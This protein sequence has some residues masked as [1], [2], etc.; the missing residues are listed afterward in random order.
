[1]VG[2]DGGGAGIELGLRLQAPAQY[3]EH[4]LPHEHTLGQQAAL[5]STLGCWVC[6]QGTLLAAASRN[7]AVVQPFPPPRLGLLLNLLPLP[8]AADCCP[9]LP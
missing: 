6:V 7:Q 5:K 2:A 8:P 1:M 3:W 4:R 9:S